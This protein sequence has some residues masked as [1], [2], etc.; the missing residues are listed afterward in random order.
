MF[1]IGHSHILT[2]VRYNRYAQVLRGV[3]YDTAVERYLS[4]R[5]ACSPITHGSIFTRHGYP[6]T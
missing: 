4:E 6:P 3:G 5:L 2:L 1:H